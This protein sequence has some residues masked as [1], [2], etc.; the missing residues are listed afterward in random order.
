MVEAVKGLRVGLSK[1]L[2][3]I[4]AG[5]A[6]SWVSEPEGTSLRARSD[7][8]LSPKQ[9][10]TSMNSLM[11]VFPSHTSAYTILQ[12]KSQQSQ[13]EAEKNSFNSC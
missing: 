9:T 8:N 10:S 13:H 12:A 11:A 7:A 4:E 3:S 6:S 1:L 2:F 5:S